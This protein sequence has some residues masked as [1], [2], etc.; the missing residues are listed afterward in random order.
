MARIR[1]IKPDF[2]R[3]PDLQDLELVNPGSCVMLVF[4]GL[5]GHC[6]KAGVFE[7]KPRMLKLDI[8]PF[9]PFDMTATLELLEQSGMV[10]RYTVDGKDYGLVPTF[11]EH[12]RIGGKE[13]TDP[14]KYPDQSGKYPGSNGEATGIAGREGKGREKEGKGEAQAPP[15]L[16]LKSWERWIAYRVEIR[17]PLKQASIPAA[18]LALAAF[19]SDQAAVVEQSIAA[20]WQ[21]LFALKTANGKPA[22]DPQA[23]DR[24]ALRK[25]AERRPAIGLADFRAPNPGE[26]AD[27]YRK[28]QDAEWS[29]RKSRPSG[30]L[31]GQVG[32]ALKVM[33]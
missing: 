18:Q 7:W 28:A 22:E 31:I 4:A 5:W 26:T 10:I 14:E 1:T 25:L 32:T 11:T 27:Q 33:Q 24:E 19:G 3:H 8:L 23:K 9:L 12:Q 29:A 2:F 6:D 20:G 15:G 30:G 21:G 16:D 17:K 13:A